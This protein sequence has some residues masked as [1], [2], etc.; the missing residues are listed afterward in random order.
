MM[1]IVIVRVAYGAATLVDVLVWTQMIIVGRV[2]AVVSVTY[3]VNMDMRADVAL[4]DLV[5]D[6]P[7]A[8]GVDGGDLSHDLS[9]VVV[10]V[11][12]VL[13]CC[14]LLFCWANFLSTCPL[15]TMSMVPVLAL[16]RF[17]R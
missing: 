17:V 3:V 6:G 4:A 16:V 5:Q 14:C 15:S 7:G 11:V 1:I 10:R 12:V 2:N 13:A 9:V 8:L